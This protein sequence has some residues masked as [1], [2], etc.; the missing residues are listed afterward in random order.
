MRLDL[1]AFRARIDRDNPML[2]LLLLLLRT[3]RSGTGAGA[4]ELWIFQG[5]KGAL[6][7]ALL[8][9]LSFARCGLLREHV[10]ALLLELDD[11][12][13]T[14]GRREERLGAVGARAVWGVQGA[15]DEAAS[16][17]ERGVFR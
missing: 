9:H 6:C 12:R 11:K 7:E 2:L 5:G 13:G 14:C 1:D 8:L 16:G 17:A 4:S 10:C 3:A 15:E